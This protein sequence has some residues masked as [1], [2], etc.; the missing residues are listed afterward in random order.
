MFGFHFQYVGVVQE[1]HMRDVLGF[2]LLL[3]GR[4]GVRVLMNAEHRGN[5]RAAHQ[6]L[7]LC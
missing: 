2:E 3:G 4:L 7:K 6:H 5:E 1:Y